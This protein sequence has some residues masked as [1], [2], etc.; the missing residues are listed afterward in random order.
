MNIV[1]IGGGTVGGAISAQLAQEG[2][3][4]TVVDNN[5]AALAELQNAFDV[6]AVEG[7]GADI[8]VL[9][10]AG[11]EKAELLIAVTSFDEINI[12]CCAAA[13]KLGTQ[14]TVARVRNPEYSELIRLMRE[15]MNLSLTI[16]PELA[17]AR[18]IYR[19]L[20]FP[21]AAKIDTCCRG[22]VE[23]VELTVPAG[24]PLCGT[25]LYDLR[26]KLNIKFLVCSVSRDG[27]VYIPSGN[28]VI[29]EGDDV[30][31]TAPDEEMTRLFKAIGVY[32]Q[33][34]R[35]VLIVGGGR[36][37]YYLE[38]LL[39]KGKIRS[40]V[41][42]KDKD[43]CHELAEQFPCNVICDNGTK[44]ELLLEEGL[45]NADAFLA[46]S[47]MD[48]ENAIV[49]MYAKTQNVR[50]VV[51]MISSMSYIDFFRGV[52]LES[53]VSPK[54]STTAFILRYVR[55][56]ANTSE[57]AEIESLHR[58]MDGQAEALEFAIKE[59]IAGLT[60]VPLKSLRSRHGVLIAC[61]VRKDEILFPTGDDAIQS[62]D[63][64][65]VISAS[66]KIKSIKDILE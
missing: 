8:S 64:V 10:K 37:T 40:T 62:G 57:D 2:H 24:S 28:F 7:N 22:R 41:I 43:L 4:I 19:M 32:K 20:R 13:K 29:E 16:N 58:L 59:D 30:C 56:M 26:G 3:A 52:G 11:A 49:S 1:V 38:G 45:E 21:S 53:I 42:E 5:A 17:A 12:L 65:I 47:E 51:T 54:S 14:H 27:K 50:K 55:G 63:T 39:Q 9:R 48:E 6:F 15:E 18:E 34:V 33:P 46:L 31:L 60:D 23:L 66:G 61:I 35:D 25:S 36:T 44:Q